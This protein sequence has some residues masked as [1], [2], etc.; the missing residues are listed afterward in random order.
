L[1]INSGEKISFLLVYN[2]WIFVVRPQVIVSD[3]GSPSLRSTATVVIRVLD[4]NDNQPKFTD[5]LFQI[6]LLE[7]RRRA[8]R[9]EV[10]RMV[11]RDDDAEGPN[12]AVTYAILGDGEE[13]EGFRIDAAT[14]AVTSHG[15]FWPGNYSILTVGGQNFRASSCRVFCFFPGLEKSWKKIKSQRFGENKFAIF[16]CSFTLSLMKRITYFAR[17]WSNKRSYHIWFLAR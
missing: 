1:C 3:N 2:S 11:A 5:K 13:D 9:R 16:I 14:G 7:R 10:C 8:G 17:L 15:D 6:K 12:A 4:A